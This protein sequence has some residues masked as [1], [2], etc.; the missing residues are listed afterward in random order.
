MS[1]NSLTLVEG[2]NPVLST[3]IPS[4]L[5]HVVNVLPKGWEAEVKNESIAMN[6]VKFHV[7]RILSVEPPV[8]VSLLQSS[9]S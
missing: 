3:K 6:C 8:P 4:Q 5:L 2:H 9:K 1:S 7:E